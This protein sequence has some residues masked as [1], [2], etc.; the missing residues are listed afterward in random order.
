MIF[1]FVD[2]VV[3]ILF[4]FLFF[5]FLFCVSMLLRG[6]IFVVEEL[7]M[8]Q[9]REVEGYYHRAR[10][11]ISL[12]RAKRLLYIYRYRG[13]IMKEIKRKKNHSLIFQLVPS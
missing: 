7:K 10:R 3:F 2:V 1:C 9:K 13:E 8:V 12:I 5:Y 4:Y 6:A 11:F